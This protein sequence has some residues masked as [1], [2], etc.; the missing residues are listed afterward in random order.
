MPGSSKLP[1]VPLRVETNFEDQP[2]VGH[3]PS[4]IENDNKY[5]TSEDLEDKLPPTRTEMNYT[6][7]EEREV[8]RKFDRRLVP[9]LAFLYLLAFL[10][11]S[12]MFGNSI[13]YPFSVKKAY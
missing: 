5:K 2:D 12:S 11:R 7:E 1:A 4:D 3:S 10:D 9:F 8:V 6:S 13:A